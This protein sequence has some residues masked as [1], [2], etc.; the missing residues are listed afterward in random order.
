MSPGALVGGARVS[1]VDHIE[2][3][4]KAR[5]KAKVM[6]HLRCYPK[7]AMTDAYY[8]Q[9][10]ALYGQPTPRDY[11][12][13]CKEVKRIGRPGYTDEKVECL[14]AWLWITEQH[15]RF[16]TACHLVGFDPDEVSS[17]VYRAVTGKKRGRPRL[18]HAAPIEE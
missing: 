15:P 2:R 18:V 4:L 1:T 8:R 11:H 13:A 7:A 6:S 3:H 16:K 10:S 14:R 5:E 12:Q 17:R 9:C